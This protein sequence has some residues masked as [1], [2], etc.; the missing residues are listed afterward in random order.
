MNNIKEFSIIVACCNDDGMGFEGHLPWKTL[1][2]DMNHFREIT[3]T[4]NDPSNKSM[5]NAIIMGR[6]TFES[7]HREQGLPNR[8]NVVISG[9]MRPKLEHSRNLI[10]LHSLG[11]A[12]LFVS[13]LSTIDKVFIIGG[14]SLYREAMSYDRCNVVYYTRVDIDIKCDV[15]FPKLHY[16]VSNES[17]IQQ[18]DIQLWDDSIQQVS[19]QFIEYRK[20]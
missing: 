5:K 6:K 1:K 20:V 12:L 2:P 14:A 9:T 19:Y 3:C 18:A 16:R 7:L 10:I 13:K 17:A 4:T 11:E 8:F 15:W